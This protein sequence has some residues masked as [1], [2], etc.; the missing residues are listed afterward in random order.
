VVLR[1]LW[2][3]P[4]LPLETLL[5]KFSALAFV[6]GLKV[7]IEVVDDTPA[8][9]EVEVDIEVPSVRKKAVEIAAEVRVEVEVGKFEK[10]VRKLV[11]FGEGSLIAG[12]VPVG[13]LGS[14]GLVCLQ[15]TFSQ[16]PSFLLHF[17][18]CF[19]RE[20]QTKRPPKIPL[21]LQK[22]LSAHET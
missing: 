11:G 16:V 17:F 13:C 9:V 20:W 3:V 21:W 12:G 1:V 22:G 2:R 14:L 15:E 18:F 6:L 8:V 10:A 5:R 4:L 19:Q 7:W